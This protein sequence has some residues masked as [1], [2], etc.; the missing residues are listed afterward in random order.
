MACAE[1]PYGKYWPV[2]NRDIAL[3]FETS[4]VSVHSFCTLL[5]VTKIFYWTQKL[6]PLILGLAFQK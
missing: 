2:N 6:L 3:R 4:L 5:K 1:G